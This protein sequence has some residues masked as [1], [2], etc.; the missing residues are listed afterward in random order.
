MERYHIQLISESSLI[1]HGL[2][3]LLNKE[4]GFSLMPQVKCS[5]PSCYKAC[6]TRETDLIIMDITS[7]T[8]SCIDCIRQIAKRHPKVNILVLIWQEHYSFV[9]EAI[10]NGAKGV[11]SME[12]DPP[13]FIEAIQTVAAGRQF[14]E[15]SLTQAIAE[16]PYRNVSNPFDLLSPREKTVLLLILKGQDTVSCASRLLI[17]KK[18]V[19]NHYTRIKKKLA[20]NDLGQ[21]TLLAIRHK[22]ILP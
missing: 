18:T 12:A 10:N 19:A 1:R 3:C 11:L 14:I 20:V 5:P 8:H 4:Q 15:P 22:F 2:L 17:S 9:N 7:G 16:V 6:S 21:L 13:L